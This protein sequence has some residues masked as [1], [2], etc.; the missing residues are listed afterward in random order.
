MSFW[1]VVAEGVVTERVANADVVVE[2]GERSD[3]GGVGGV[4]IDDDG[5]PEAK[6]AEPD[7]HRSDI[8]AEDRV[9]ENVAAD[10]RGGAGIAELCAEDGET[11]EG[12]DEDAAGAAGGVED[13]K[14]V[15][16][17]EEAVAVGGREGFAG[18]CSAD[19]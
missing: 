7:G 1:R 11:F 12:G 16:G 15:D 4:V 13:A 8:D 18:E 17:G 3:I 5:E 9:C 2:I 6:F 14:I 10:D 19:E